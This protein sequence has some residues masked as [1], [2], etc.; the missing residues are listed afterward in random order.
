MAR[1][2]KYDRE[3]LLPLILDRIAAGETLVSICAEPGMPHHDT[4]YE[5]I[6]DADI[7]PRLARARALGADALARDALAILDESPERYATEHGTRVDPGYVAWQKQRAEQRMKLAAVFDASR[8]GQKA[9]LEHTG[10]GG[11]PI[12]SISRVVLVDLVAENAA[13]QREN[14]D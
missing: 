1:P 10:K 3:K 11:G 4:I 6:E 2:R 12:E 8:Y 7:T 9:Q 13:P 5:W 14:R